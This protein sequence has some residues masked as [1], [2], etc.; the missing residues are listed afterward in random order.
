M[1]IESANLTATV[2]TSS[3]VA[4]VSQ[5]VTEGGLG[6]DGFSAALDTQVGLLSNIKMGET[7]PMPD[8]SGLQGA[9]VGPVVAGVSAAT[10]ETQTV[11]ALLGNTLPPS[12]PIKDEA[13][14]QAALAA[15]TDAWKYIA[16]VATAGDTSAAAEKN[17]NDVIAMTIPLQQNVKDLSPVIVP[18]QNK[19]NAVATIAVPIEQIQAVMDRQSGA[20]VGRDIQA[21]LNLKQINDKSDKKQDE[22]VEQVVNAEEVQGTDGLVP[23]IILPVILPIEQGTIVNNPATVDVT[24][25]ELPLSFI[26]VSGS[27]GKPNQSAIAA[28]TM[29]QS[30]IVMSQPVQDKPVSSLQNLD[31]GGQT[32]KAGLLERQG[33]SVEGNKPLSGTG[34][35]ITQLNKPGTDNKV[36]IPAITKPLA[37]PEWNKDLSERIVWM[38]SKAI[39]AAEI[40]LNPEHLGPIS[41]RVNVTDDQATVVFT[42]QH[43]LTREALEASIPKLREMMSSQQLNL[44]DVSIGSASD[45]GRSSSQNFAQTA[46]DSGQGVADGIDDVEQEID[47]GRAAVSKGLLS[48]YA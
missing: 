44:V 1:N 24:E 43:A 21:Q 18:E 20:G 30:A 31:G 41:V 19:S 36:D 10:V 5:P 33:L 40:R 12:Y 4:S 42:A 34:V 17:L 3:P 2:T 8:F 38:S 6:S 15:V 37:H 26:S 22:G 9:A 39:P 29:P 28:D 11:A 16:T 46:K 27:N 7:M 32:E 25:Q 45:Q 13:D 23:V 14:H 48:I 35:D 47:N